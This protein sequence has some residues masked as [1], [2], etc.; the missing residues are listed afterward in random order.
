MICQGGTYLL[1]K[2]LTPQ[3]EAAGDQARIIITSSG[4][5]SP[6]AGLLFVGSFVDRC[7]VDSR[8]SL[9]ECMEQA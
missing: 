6:I 4:T 3:L 2:L 7:C 1:A 8:E 9:I 5:C